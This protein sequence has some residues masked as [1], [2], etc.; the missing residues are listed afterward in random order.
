MLLRVS[1]QWTIIVKVTTCARTYYAH[2][3]C[4]CVEVRGTKFL[5]CN[6][7]KIKCAMWDAR[8]QKSLNFKM[9]TLLYQNSIS[10]RISYIEIPTIT[11][12]KKLIHL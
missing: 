5:T 10:T 6:M 2:A 12:Q 3:P 9:I 4:S 8:N 11:R 7:E 1:N